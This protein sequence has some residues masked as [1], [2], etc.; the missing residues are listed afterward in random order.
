MRTARH[1]KSSLLLINY[2]ACD[3]LRWY[4]V[5]TGYSSCKERP[6]RPQHR[7]M[8]KES[9]SGSEGSG[10][11]PQARKAIQ[12]QDTGPAG[13]HSDTAAEQE[14]RSQHS[15]KRH[16]SGSQDSD[17]HTGAEKA[18]EVQAKATKLVG[19]LAEPEPD[20]AKTGT[21]ALAE[22]RQKDY[23]KHMQAK[24]WADMG[25]ADAGPPTGALSS[26]SG[27]Q[28]KSSALEDSAEA[29][30]L[31][32]WQAPQRNEAPDGN[33][34][35][36]VQTHKDVH[37]ESATVDT[38]ASCAHNKEATHT[39]DDNHRNGKEQTQHDADQPAQPLQGSTGMRDEIEQFHQHEGSKQAQDE[40]KGSQ[41]ARPSGA[42]QDRLFDEQT[43]QHHPQNDSEEA[44]RSVSHCTSPVPFSSAL[45]SHWKA[46]VSCLCVLH[47]PICYNMREIL[48]SLP[49]VIQQLQKAQQRA[50]DEMEAAEKQAS[51]LRFP[52]EAG[53]RFVTNAR[54]HKSK[55]D[56]E[57]FEH[58]THVRSNQ[59]HH[60]R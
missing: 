20:L 17:Q 18:A 11:R 48:C 50:H 24:P 10:P 45:V 6:K 3:L 34:P 52:A 39:A 40:H 32:G 27:Q 25:G 44:K 13:R 15:S 8:T 7:H 21:L 55:L 14:H 41:G 57:I 2:K 38:Q 22:K 60:S 26:L 29:R 53:Q 51:D 58:G 49:P 9:S 5:V 30:R 36:Q 28:P 46:T 37:D 4:L 56:T 12:P 35:A 54:K 31:P 33:Q 23:N 42:V 19:E 16:R 1:R 43:Q 59:T 47:T